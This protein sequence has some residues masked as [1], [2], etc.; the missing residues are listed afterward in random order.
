MAALVQNMIHN[1]IIHGSNPL[2]I[3]NT[4]QMDMNNGPIL[5]SSLAYLRFSCGPAAHRFFSDQAWK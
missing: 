2:G 3:D 1:F 5:L 4:E